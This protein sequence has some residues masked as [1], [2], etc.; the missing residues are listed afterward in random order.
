MPLL[1]SDK[2]YL[3]EKG[4]EYQ[5]CENSGGL[6]VVLKGYK[7]SDLY[8]PRTVDLLVKIPPL[9]PNNGL[10]MFWGYPHVFLVNG[11][12][13]PTCANAFEDLLGQKWQ[14]FS[15]HYQWRPGTDCLASHLMTVQ[16]ALLNPN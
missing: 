13:Y 10:D 6:L 7:L 12:Q 3:E 8:T 4:L 5:I 16:K 15:R 11:N 9:Y 14:R 2:Q 1:E